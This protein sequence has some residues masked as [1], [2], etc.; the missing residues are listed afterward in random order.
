MPPALSIALITL[1]AILLIMAGEAA[2]SAHNERVLRAQGASEPPD[3]VYR[4]MQFAY[5]AC[6]VLM[7]AEGTFTGPA[8]RDVLMAGLA[9][10]GLSK[11]LKISAI[12][13][14]GVRWTF[15]VLVPPGAPLV[16][17]GPYRVVRHPNYVA[18]VGELAACGLIVWAPV[19]G[20][21]SVVGFGWLIAR[22][23]RVEE[24]ALGRQ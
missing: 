2:L 18:V 3:D 24:R 19:T 17:S 4:W 10:F 21:L 1:L 22:R 11:A 6:F 15:R 5:P 9:L 12:S 20:V 23:I 13:A 16:Q 8:P 14:L 7:A